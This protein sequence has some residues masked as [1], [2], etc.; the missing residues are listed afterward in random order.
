MS[1]QLPDSAKSTSK[2]STPIATSVANTRFTPKSQFLTRSGRNAVAIYKSADVGHDD[3]KL[4]LLRGTQTLPPTRDSHAGMT[5]ARA[6]LG[7][8]PDL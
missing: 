6:G 7:A 8:L 1:P 3:I 2:P 4:Q 5:E